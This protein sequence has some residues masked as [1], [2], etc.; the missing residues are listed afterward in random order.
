M[1]K[2]VAL[3]VLV[4]F[5]IASAAHACPMCKDSI[6][7]SDAQQAGSLPIGFNHSVYFLLVGFMT[8]LG[9]TVAMIVKAVR[10]T[11]AAQRPGFQVIEPKFRQPPTS[12]RD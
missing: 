8:V 9:T 7:S 4:T 1:I 12:H 11:N 2:R 3:C 10:A 5:A 6:P